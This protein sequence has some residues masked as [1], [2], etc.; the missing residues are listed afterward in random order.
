MIGRRVLDLTLTLRSPFLFSGTGG[1][2]IGLDAVALR[3]HEGCPL[4]PQDQVRGIVRHGLNDVALHAADLTQADV[5]SMFGVS[6]ADATSDD[7]EDANTFAPRR[8]RLIFSDLRAELF[9]G[10]PLTNTR[11]SIDTET[12][13]AKAGHLNVVELVAP[14]GRAVAFRGSIVFWG[15]EAEGQLWAARIEAAFS[16]ISSIGAMKSSGFGEVVSA[17]CLPKPQTT[18]PAQPKR[19]IGKRLA[20]TFS[21]DRP[22]LV[23][24]QRI[25]DNYYQGEVVVPGGA[26][27]GALAERLRVLGHDPSAMDG[28]SNLVITHAKPVGYS[29]VLSNAIV[30]VSDGDSFEFADAID[31]PKGAG[32]LINGRAAKFTIDWKDELFGA[33][34]NET[35]KPPLYSP[36]FD[37][38]T[39]VRI[40]QSTG[41]AE[42]GM[43]Y[44][45]G[46]VSPG[47]KDRWQCTLDFD[48]V[49]E[50]QQALL[51]DVFRSGLDGVG[52]TNASLCLTGDLQAR[53]CP[54][55]VER[56]DGS[57]VV[58][59]TSDAFMADP[60]QGAC[61]D[62]FAS[63][64][65]RV[66]GADLQNMFAS[67]RWAGGY[68]ARRFQSSGVYRPFCLT[69]R[70]SVFRLVGADKKALEALLRK[71]LPTIGATSWRENPFQPQNGYGHFVTL[72]QDTLNAR[73]V[74]YV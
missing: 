19:P 20:A 46:A 64:W 9:G 18:A 34:F 56:P 7:I 16:W 28:L 37:V 72:K 55:L 58:M 38:R 51:T 62:A 63:Y 14:K 29:E 27:K 68:I 39:H 33:Y 23:N 53:E 36:D 1:L 43:L 15:T 73:E 59:L 8:G 61:F 52:R 26:I 49:D 41:A 69:S 31:A 4:I 45:S 44:V 11:V 40:E 42:H 17:A 70:G 71:G 21:F 24:A 32:I 2:N 57:V 25:A 13:S 66:C 12:G 67:Q 5:D 47:V 54:K 22:F 65:K 50:K 3:D 48:S 6:A 35:G 30:G 60:T 74:E 10:M